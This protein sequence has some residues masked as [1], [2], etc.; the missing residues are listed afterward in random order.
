MTNK[1]TGTVKKWK[2]DRGF[3][4]ISIGADEDLFFH[5]S[6]VRSGVE[7]READRVEFERGVNPKNNKPQAVNVV[8]LR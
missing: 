5:V 6:Q 1:E 2:E 7:P 4:F 3:G 8:V